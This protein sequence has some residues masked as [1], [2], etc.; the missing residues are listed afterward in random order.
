MCAV[1]AGS[2]QEKGDGETRSWGGRWLA[3]LVP[4]LQRSDGTIKHDLG[5]Q[6]RC[7]GDLAAASLLLGLEANGNT[8]GLSPWKELGT[9]KVDG[10][11]R[12]ERCG[13]R[14]AA[15]HAKRP[16]AAGPETDGSIKLLSNS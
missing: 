8:A 3:A 9:A 4:E 1:V 16:E 11:E 2:S 14:R 12:R 13:G 10:G 15:G 5:R 7:H 6:I